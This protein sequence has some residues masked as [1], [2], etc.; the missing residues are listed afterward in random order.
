[1]GWSR[2]ASHL[3]AGIARLGRVRP[4]RLGW[5]KRAGPFFGNQIG[6]LLLADGRARFQLSVTERDHRG[7]DRL[8]RVLDLPLTEG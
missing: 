2:W 6:E 8:R 4:S 1:M 7:Q 3:T 5:A